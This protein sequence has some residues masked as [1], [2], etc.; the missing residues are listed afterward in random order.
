MRGLSQNGVF[1]GEAVDDCGDEPPGAA[2]AGHIAAA[3]RQDG[4][5]VSKSEIWRDS[6]W[7]FVAKVDGIEEE[8]VIARALSGEWLVQVTPA[9]SPGLISRLFRAGDHP[10]V[11]TTL[12]VARAIHQSLSSDSRFS[13]FRWRWDGPPVDG[14]PGQPTARPAT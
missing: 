6:G 12:E 14:D 10:A 11:A 7:R 3:L 5:A 4:T 8:I 2:L 9:N 13:G 1:A